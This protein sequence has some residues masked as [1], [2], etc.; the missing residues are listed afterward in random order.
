M[1]SVFYSFKKYFVGCKKVIISR[2]QKFI[3]YD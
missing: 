2:K 1:F 3:F